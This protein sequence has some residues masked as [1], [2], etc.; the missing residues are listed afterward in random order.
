MKNRDTES[1]R[2]I[3]TS[4]VRLSAASLTWFPSQSARATSESVY[5]SLYVSEV[6]EGCPSQRVRLTEERFSH[7]VRSQPLPQHSN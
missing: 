6:A 2:R 5:K 3:Y 7:Q 4:S 1:S